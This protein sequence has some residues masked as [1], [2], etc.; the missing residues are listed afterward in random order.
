MWHSCLT[1]TKGRLLYG[2]ALQQNYEIRGSHFPPKNC[3]YRQGVLDITVIKPEQCVEAL[4]SDHNS[5]TLFMDLEPHETTMPT[6]DPFKANWTYYRHLL[7][8]AIQG[9]PNNTSKKTCCSNHIYF[10]DNQGGKKQ[11]LRTISHIPTSRLGNPRSQRALAKTCTILTEQLTA[12][13]ATS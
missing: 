1:N 12:G 7:N 10:N 2:H 3:N 4:S 5:V 11:Q 13:N 9:N 6:T 8:Q